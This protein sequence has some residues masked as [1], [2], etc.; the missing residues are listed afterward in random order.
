M[1]STAVISGMPESRR[2]ATS[3]RVGQSV[4]NAGDGCGSGEVLRRDSTW[5]GDLE[6]QKERK[7]KERKK[8]L[9]LF[10]LYL[11]LQYIH[12]HTHTHTLS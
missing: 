11:S 8:I 3:G 1:K 10:R 12:T 4:E 2:G 9:S 6:R 5:A 7:K